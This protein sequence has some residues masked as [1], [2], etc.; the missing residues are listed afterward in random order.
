MQCM[1]V[2]QR[3]SALAKSFHGLLDPTTHKPVSG[4]EP[5]DP[6]RLER[7]AN[8]P[9]ATGGSRL[10]AL[11]CLAVWRGRALPYLPERDE[12]ER[13][14]EQATNAL[15]EVRSLAFDFVR[16]MGIWDDEHRRAFMAWAMDPFFP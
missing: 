2:E 12:V 3:M 14:P 13:R 15:A 16:A 10:A 9:S 11:A 8:G 5:W 7:W 1:T 4:V 6:A